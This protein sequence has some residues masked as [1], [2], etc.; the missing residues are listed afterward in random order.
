M[1]GRFHICACAPGGGLYLYVKSCQQAGFF[2]ILEDFDEAEST[3]HGC[4]GSLTGNGA[5]H[6]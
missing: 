3:N 5:D 2:C 1:S 4:H 6:T